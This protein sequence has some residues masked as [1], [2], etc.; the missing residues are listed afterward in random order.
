M[1]EPKFY[2]YIDK[3]NGDCV[4]VLGVDV[5]GSC[6]FQEFFFIDPEPFERPSVK[7]VDF[8]QLGQE[9]CSRAEAETLLE[10]HRQAGEVY[11]K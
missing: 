1:A 2:R 4:G 11:L 8:L 6:P 7:P 9:E 3:R 5:S 10:F